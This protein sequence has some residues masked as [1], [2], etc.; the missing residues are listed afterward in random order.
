MEIPYDAVRQNAL[1]QGLS[2][3]ELEG[4]FRAGPCPMVEFGKDTLLYLQGERC[5]GMD[6]ILEG[7]VSVQKIDTEGNVL[8]VSRF[9]RGDTLGENL[10]FSRDGRFPMTIV[11]D[12]EVRLLRMERE[13]LLAMCQQDGRILSRLLTSISDKTLVLADTISMLTSGSLRRR[14]AEYLLYEYRI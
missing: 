10:L 12:C 4:L 9:A 11:S 8:L 2:D 3:D 5:R 7:T 14:I 6:L 13:T 1:F